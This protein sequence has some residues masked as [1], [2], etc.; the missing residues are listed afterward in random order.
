MWLP[1]QSPLHNTIVFFILGWQFFFN[2]QFSSPDSKLLKE[3]DNLFQWSASYCNSHNLQNVFLLTLIL[4]FLLI[5]FRLNFLILEVFLFLYRWL[6]PI[7]N[8]SFDWN[9]AVYSALHR[10]MLFWNDKSLLTSS[11]SL[12]LSLFIPN[13]IIRRM[14]LYAKRGFVSTSYL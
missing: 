12:V 1:R 9:Y 5:T 10:S 14:I 11:D 3:Q 6:I 7:P 8:I 2:G 13:A 4:N